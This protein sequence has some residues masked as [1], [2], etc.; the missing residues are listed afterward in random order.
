MK[1]K[2]NVFERLRVWWYVNKAKALYREVHNQ[3]GLHFSVKNI[4]K[5]KKVVHLLP[6]ETVSLFAD[7]KTI[8]AV[9]VNDPFFS[10]RKCLSR[11]KGFSNQELLKQFSVTSWGNLAYICLNGN[12]SSRR[13]A[14]KGKLE[15]MMLLQATLIKHKK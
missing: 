2:E 6:L 12:E 4:E 5:F 14:L 3:Y 10:P 7:Q 1:K 13:S 9:S 11:L 8:N 15:K